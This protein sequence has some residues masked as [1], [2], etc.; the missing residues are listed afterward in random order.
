[1]RAQ[2]VATKSLARPAA[3]LLLSF[4]LGGPSW[5]AGVVT[6]NE[7]T[8]ERCPGSSCSWRLACGVGPGQETQLFTGAEARTKYDVKIG[9]SLD[10]AKMPAAVHCTAWK[11]DGWLWWE[12][13]NKVGSGSVE[14][15]AGGDYKIGISS[16]EEGA[17][18]VAISVDSLEITIPEPAPEVPAKPAKKGKAAPA[19]PAPVWRFAATFVPAPGGRAVVVGMEGKPFKEMV[20]KLRARGIQIEDVET[21]EAGGKR[22]WSGIF[23][24]SQ[25][26]VVLLMD[27]DWDKFSSAW[28]KLTGSKMRLTDLEIYPVG[29][30]LTF[31]GIFRDL[32]ESH[33]F[34]VGKKRDEFE[35]LV[36]D[37]SENKGQKLLDVEVY[38]PSHGG[39]LLYAGPFR[40][41]S[42]DTKLWANM[43]RAAF[44]SKLAGLRGKEWQVI[45]LAT[46]KEGK[47]RA[48]DAII[49]VG[50]PGQVLLDA[51]EA[52]L[53][54][55]WRDLAKKG[56]RLVSLETYQE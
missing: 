54:A 17:V 44:E 49:R 24:N 13:W 56:L 36:K 29:G 28:K 5:A 20:G 32:G 25:E 22:L 27:E 50:E 4:L 10:V 14:V 55:R 52:A 19:K 45:G 21:F 33:A 38:Q 6:F 31:A 34:W 18:S 12:S 41:M 53:T 40:Q 42:L 30:K 46:Y 51:N 16:R 3:F 39:S 26:Q 23:R 7:M 35:A 47:E 37:L 1:M 48:F 2:P 8:A 9:R 11:D 15:P 43:S